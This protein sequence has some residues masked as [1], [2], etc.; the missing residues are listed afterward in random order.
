ML[1]PVAE[2]IFAFGESLDDI[3]LPVDPAAHHIFHLPSELMTLGSYTRSPSESLVWDREAVYWSLSTLTGLTRTAR[4]AGSAHAAQA[5][6]PSNTIT[7]PSTVGSKGR[8]P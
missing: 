7:V 3:T 6:N 1:R 4:R 5:T 2:A 8:T